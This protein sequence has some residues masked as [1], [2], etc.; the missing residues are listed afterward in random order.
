MPHSTLPPLS[1]AKFSADYIIDF[2][3]YITGWNERDEV[4]EKT[5]LKYL[6]NYLAIDHV[7]CQTVIAESD[8]I[9]R[10]YLEDYAEYYARCFPSHPKKCSRL[11]FFS[12]DFTSSDFRRCLSGNNQALKKSLKDSYLGFAVIRPIPHTVFARLCL[13]PYSALLRNPLKKVLT[14]KVEVSLFGLALSVETIPFIEQDKVVSA[15]ATSALW[16]ALGA[17]TDIS[18]NLLPSPSAITKAATNGGAEAG[19]IFPTAGLSPPQILR[20]LRHF[21]L[22]PSIAW[23]AENSIQDLKALIYGY[24][25][26]DMTII[27]GGE[28]Y[29]RSGSG[30]THLGAHLVCV[31]G[32]SIK[33]G[34]TPLQ[35]LKFHSDD[36]DKIY[37]HDDRSGPYL[38]LS[39]DIQEFTRGKQKLEGMALGVHEAQSHI[40]IPTIAIV[41]A[42]HKIRIPYIH[43]QDVCVA[44]HAYLGESV[45]SAVPSGGDAERSSEMHDGAISL[46]KS[47]WEIS[48]ITST[49]LK[50]DVIE[51]KNFEAYNGIQGKNSLLLQN[52]PRFLWRCRI[53]DPKSGKRLSDILFDATEVPQGNVLVGYIAW[54]LEASFAWIFVRSQIKT[55][56]W[57]G[58]RSADKTKFRDLAGCFIKFF[59]RDENDAFLNTAYG[60]I[61]LPQRSLKSG[62]TDVNQNITIRTDV[63]KIIPRASEN[64]SWN[65]LDRSKKYIWVIDAAGDIIIGEDIASS[66]QFQGHPTLTDGKPGRIAGEL[67]AVKR[68]GSTGWRLNLQSRTYSQHVTE[69]IDMINYLEQVVADNLRGLNVKVDYSWVNAKVETEAPIGGRIKAGEKNKAVKDG[70]SER[71]S[72]A[73]A[74]SKHSNHSNVSNPKNIS[75]R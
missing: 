37:V 24:L 12:S 1:V 6:C 23:S 44:F 67:N 2:V 8:Y 10:H 74:R 11:H 28:M 66:G 40:F 59:S 30:Y 20:G 15:C 38:R 16:V 26:N 7:N 47:C 71:K 58:M 60:P 18:P 39:T 33:K 3:R 65:F 70:M 32:Y 4:S 43:I 62:E 29:E 72:T 50:Q 57:Q 68:K 17:H 36:M 73:G 19:R 56:V 45:R 42:Y 48:L 69:K 46:L 35:G 13:R 64:I 27:L 25:S 5:Q 53:S 31:T 22:E 21:G 49:K 54:T 63:P 9:D 55:R 34:L 51:S 61:G 52:M 14:R 41:G 75:A